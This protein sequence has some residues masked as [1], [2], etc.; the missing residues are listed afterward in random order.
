MLGPMR[1]GRRRGGG[2]LELVD[3]SLSLTGLGSSGFC[4]PFFHSSMHSN[5]L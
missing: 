2:G 3:G 5:R 1:W 4:S